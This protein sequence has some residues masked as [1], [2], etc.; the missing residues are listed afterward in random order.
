M[1]LVPQAKRDAEADKLRA[2]LASLRKMLKES[3]RVLSHLMKQESALKAEGR[4]L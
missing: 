4:G 1:A 2:Q 3:H